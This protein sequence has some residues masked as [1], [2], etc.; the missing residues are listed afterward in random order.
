MATNVIISDELFEE[1]LSEIGF[2]IFGFEEFPYD[3]DQVKNLFIWPA[4]RDY[5]RYFPLVNQQEASVSENFEI[6]FPRTTT[7]SVVDGRLNTNTVQSA[8]LVA[9][10]F[11]NA[12]SLYNTG[13]GYGGRYGTRYSYQQETAYHTSRSE[14]Q[15][16]KTSQGAFRF[17]VDFNERKIIGYSNIHGYML[18]SWADWSYDFGTIPFD[19]QSDVMEL[20]RS[21]IFRGWGNQL[22]LQSTDLTN[23]LNPDFMLD[24]AEDLEE[25]VFTRWNDYSKPILLRR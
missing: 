13:Y 23:E 18:I 9:D 3:E 19:K 4:M 22:S 21:K 17:Y 12:A 14:Y 15:A 7:F 2:P 20:C 25:K 8:S 6:D 5:F 11:V 1:I 24:R 10:P 16:N